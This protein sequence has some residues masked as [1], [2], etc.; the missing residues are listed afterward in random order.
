MVVGDGIAVGGNEEAG[1]LPH[2]DAIAAAATAHARRQ[3][4]GTAELA[5]ET[6]HRR[7]RLERRIIVVVVVALGDFLVEIDLHRNHRRLHALDDVGKAD[8][9]LDLA[10]LV[11]DLGMR[12]RGEYVHRT[13][14][15]ADAIDG[16][17][18]ARHHGRHQRELA[19]RK[20]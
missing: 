5:E 3:P 10:N 18:E 4:V 6:L 1:T 14:R 7:T 11:G 17:A 8:R 15:R 16:D 20:R 9:L 2:D 13:T 19:G 12:R